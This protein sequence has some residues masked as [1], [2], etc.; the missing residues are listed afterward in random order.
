LLAKQDRLSS[1][2]KDE[3]L[4]AVLAGSA[5][6]KQ[7]LRWWFGLVPAAA[8]ALLVLVAPWRSERADLAARGGG[9]PFA[10]FRPICSG[11]CVTGQK[12]TFDLQG[13]TGYRYFAAFSKRPDGTVLWY[14]PSS[15]AATSVDLVAQPTG[16]LLD[17]SIVIGDDHPAGAYRVYGVFSRE[18]LTRAQIR[19]AFDE[20]LR[21]A[22]PGTQVIETEIVVR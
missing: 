16:G 9:Q 15:D 21:T 12:I 1:V 17:Q 6:A 18:P 8:I 19:T 13:T 3:I 7:R 20:S 2:E 5:P 4:D 22:G 10:S 14:F 11:E